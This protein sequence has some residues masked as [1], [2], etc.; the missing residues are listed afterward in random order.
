[1]VDFQNNLALFVDGKRLPVTEDGLMNAPV[2]R[3]LQ[4]VLSP[5]LTHQNRKTIAVL[6]TDLVAKVLHKEGQ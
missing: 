5:L 1:M 6:L 2:F 3:V 4:E